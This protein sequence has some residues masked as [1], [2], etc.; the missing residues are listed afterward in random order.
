M[1]SSVFDNEPLLNRKHVSQNRELGDIKSF[2][3]AHRW[4]GFMRG[5]LTRQEQPR[6]C[7]EQ[8]HLRLF[9]RDEPRECLQES[10]EYTVHAQVFC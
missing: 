3:K 9:V 7:F 4:K 10:I 8:K 5:C 6:T 2:G 1:F